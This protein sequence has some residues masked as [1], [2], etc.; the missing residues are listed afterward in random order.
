MGESYKTPGLQANQVIEERFPA[1][2]RLGLQAVVVSLVLGLILG[3]LAFNRGRWIDFVTIFIA[4][5]GVSIR[6]SYLQLYYR[7][8]EQEVISQLSD[9][10]QKE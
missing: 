3:I 10:Q 7:N 9:G 1:S 2:L 4:I 8:M 5:L 6:A